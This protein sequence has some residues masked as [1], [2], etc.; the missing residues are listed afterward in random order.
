MILCAGSTLIAV[1]EHSESI[2]ILNDGF[3]VVN[4]SK[5]KLADQI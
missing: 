3:D 5:T 1:W 2:D 4:D